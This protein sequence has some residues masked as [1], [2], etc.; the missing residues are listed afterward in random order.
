[1]EIYEDPMAIHGTFEGMVQITDFEASK[2]M[3]V[4]SG[5][6]EWF[7][8]NSSVLPE[9]KKDNVTGI[10]FRI[11]D[12]CCLSGSCSPSPP[13]GVNLPNL[14]WIREQ[15]GSK[16][17]SLGNILEGYAEGGK[18]NP[19]ASLMNEFFLD[20]EK[21]ERI[22][23]YGSVAQNVHV[24][25]HEVL[26][27]ASGKM[28][29]GKDYKDLGGD[30][31]CLEEARADL[32]AL[33]Y[34]LDP[35]LAELKVI[36][37]PMKEGAAEY[38]SYITS[39]LMMQLVRIKPGKDIEEAHQRNRYLIAQWV[40]EKGAPENVIEKIVKDGKTYFNITDYQKLRK[41]FGDLLREVQRIKSQADV[42]ALKALVATYAVKVDQDI[43]KEVLER[44]SKLDVKPSTLF[45]SPQIVPNED[46][47]E[48]KIEY[49]EDYLEQQLGYLKRYNGQ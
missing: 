44:V 35:K 30:Y 29:P 25:L 37:D 5:N 2:R 15:H 4:L 26:G 12:V 16:S 17:V 49:P 14:D 33:Y 21:I 10:T 43:H 18:A 38:D 24:A 23:E 11:V 36:E 40:L 13:I 42:P 28:E 32:F 19:K 39:A 47:S 27:H 34:T 6:A 9:H 45:I 46:L 20:Q 1:V 31:S 7:E 22:K 41:L 3:A 8:K 48:V